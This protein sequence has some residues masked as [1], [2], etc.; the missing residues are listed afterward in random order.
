VTLDRVGS[1]S[2][3]RLYL[4]HRSVVVARDIAPPSPSESCL[5]LRRVTLRGSSIRVNRVGGSFGHGNGCS[6]QSLRLDA[7]SPYIENCLPRNNP[8]AIICVP[9]HTN[10]VYHDFT[11]FYIAALGRKGSARATQPRHTAIPHH[12]VVSTGAKLIKSILNESEI[13]KKSALV[14]FMEIFTCAIFNGAFILS[15]LAKDHPE[16]ETSTE[17]VELTIRNEKRRHRIYDTGKCPAQTRSRTC[18]RRYRVDQ[19][20]FWKDGEGHHW[21]CQII[22]IRPQNDKFVIKFDDE[23]ITEQREVERSEISPD[24]RVAGEGDDNDDEMQYALSKYDESFAAA[25]DED[26]SYLLVQAACGEFTVCYD[27]S[28][29]HRD[30]FTHC[31]GALLENKESF[32][33]GKPD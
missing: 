19:A 28:A 17:A 8:E 22:E 13:K 1:S 7:V 16:L 26:M 31:D 29:S 11:P 25:K 33:V 14:D 2:H 30:A 27:T 5:T 21:A 10:G 3:I 6:L 15:H 23:S 12:S 18:S 32:I 20:V 24:I 4:K 9:F